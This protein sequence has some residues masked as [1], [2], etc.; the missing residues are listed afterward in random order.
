MKG[1]LLTIKAVSRVREALRIAVIPAQA[2][3]DL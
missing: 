2:G 1:S 3:G